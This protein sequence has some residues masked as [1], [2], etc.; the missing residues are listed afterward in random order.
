MA[1]SETSR[2]LP[3]MTPRNI[4][5]AAMIFA[6]G[7][8]SKPICSMALPS[9]IVKPLGDSAF[10][11]GRDWS[12][13]HERYAPLVHRRRVLERELV[14]AIPTCEIELRVDSEVHLASTKEESDDHLGDQ[15]EMVRVREKS[16]RGL[17]NLDLASEDADGRIGYS[18]VFGT[19]REAHDLCLK[20]GQSL[21]NIPAKSVA[22]AAARTR[23]FIETNS[24]I[25][26]WRKDF[27]PAFRRIHDP[28]F[29][30]Q[31]SL[32][33]EVDRVEAGNA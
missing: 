3:K 14:C 27:S 21:W 9:P 18:R 1:D 6:S 17:S 13:V 12:A 16:L 5:S 28:S 23:C 33:D 2:I 11:V 20:L 24:P 25:G 22:G 30:D 10:L 7:L 15:P 31:R 19:E 26:P 29:P 4:L 32:L 8:A